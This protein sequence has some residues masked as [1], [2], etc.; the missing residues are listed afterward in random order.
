MLGKK[1]EIYTKL[2]SSPEEASKFMAYI[3]R[4]RNNVLTLLQLKQFLTSSENE[5]F[6]R[7]I[8][9]ITY[10]KFKYFCLGI[11]SSPRTSWRISTTQ[12]SNADMNTCLFDPPS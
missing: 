2:A 9:V 1:T 5:R 12:R 11:V 6:A 4:N 10:S 3:K 8:R 7:I